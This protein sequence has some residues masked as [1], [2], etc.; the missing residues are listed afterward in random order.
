M[1]SYFRLIIYSPQISPEVGGGG[2]TA[3]AAGLAA[4]AVADAFVTELWPL[5][6]VSGIFFCWQEP[7]MVN[8]DYVVS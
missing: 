2:V 5:A 8:S 1:G 7:D 6:Y 3:A 4:A